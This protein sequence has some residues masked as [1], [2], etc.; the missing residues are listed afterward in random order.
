MDELL[1]RL[2]KKFSSLIEVVRG[3]ESLSNMKT[4]REAVSFF[5]EQIK[6]DRPT[7][8]RQDSSVGRATVL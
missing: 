3:R 6:V 4:R 7:S 1:H 8:R 5:L 2:E